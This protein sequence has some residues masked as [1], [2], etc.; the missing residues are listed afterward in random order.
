MAEG[1][2]FCISYSL[3]PPP[4]KEKLRGHSPPLP[5]PPLSLSCVAFPLPRPSY[6]SS[7][8]KQT[9]CIGFVKHRVLQITQLHQKLAENPVEYASE[10]ASE[11]T[12]RRTHAYYASFVSAS[13]HSLLPH[14]PSS[15]I[16]HSTH[17]AQA[18]S[19]LGRADHFRY[20]AKGYLSPVKDA[21]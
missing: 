2:R 17:R 9:H 12:L 7:L 13:V 4:W 3:T 20:A 5:P 16:H 19:L 21:A 14:S 15:R 11:Y 1:K 10:Y 6:F 18:C 8:S